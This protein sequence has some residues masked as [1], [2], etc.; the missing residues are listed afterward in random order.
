MV[1]QARIVTPL[2]GA[3]DRRGG[4]SKA[5]F[6]PSNKSHTRAFGESKA[7]DRMSFTTHLGL[8]HGSGFV[9]NQRPVLFNKLSLDLI[10][11]PQF[12]L[13]LC[14]SFMSQTKQHY[15]PPIHSDGS[16]SLPSVLNKPRASGFHHVRS[17][18]KAEPVE[19]KSEYQSFFVPHHLTPSVSHHMK[20]GPKVETGFTKGTN[21]Q[22]NTFQD[23]KSCILEPQTF[24]SVM[25]SDFLPP[26]FPKVAESIRRVHSHS[27][28]ETGYTRGAIAP[29]AC[30]SSL[31]QSPETRTN[32]PV[33]KTIGKKE[34]TGFLLNTPNEIFPK[35]SFEPSHFTTH[36][37]SKFSCGYQKDRNSVSA[38][39]IINTSHTMDSGYNHRDTDRFILKN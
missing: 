7:L 5:T 31:L 20:L 4:L 14:D 26:S 23:K 37:N 24:S 38:A 2:V 21:L 29:L 12:G 39:G 17:L 16:G 9:S 6:R 35:R 25:K 28:K 13:L 19:A 30:P 27:V 36:Y 34:H 32:A 8:N 11:N 10:D 22:L 3:T 18:S 33:V 1:G 15:Q